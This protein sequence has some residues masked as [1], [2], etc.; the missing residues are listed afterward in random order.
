MFNNF[1]K[2]NNGHNSKQEANIITDI[3]AN[4]KHNSKQEANIITNIIANKKQ[5]Q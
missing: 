1:N 2:R 3:R 4:N 5:M